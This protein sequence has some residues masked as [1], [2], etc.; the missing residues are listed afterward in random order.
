MSDPSPATAERRSGGHRRRRTIGQRLAAT[1]LALLL[2]GAAGGLT[3]AAA[4]GLGWLPSG[5]ETTA[6]DSACDSPA[7]VTIA[8]DP[9]IAPAVEQLA[10][11]IPCAEVT[12]AA[13]PS[14]DIAAAASRAA[15][16]GLGS[17]LPDLWIPDSS[18]WVE[19][20]RSTSEGAARI[21]GAPRSLAST[22]VVVA[23]ADG[24][25]REL[26]WPSQQPTW[27]DLLTNQSSLRLLTPDPR[28]N[29]AALV[30]LVA[31]SGG[32]PTTET[33][34][35]VSRRLLT[36]GAG[37]ASPAGQI[38]NGSI[39]AAPTTE[40]DVLSVTATPEGEGKVVAAYDPAL[41]PA[42]DFPLV[43]LSPEQESPE[44][45]A[46]VQALSGALTSD[47]A[48][49]AYATLGL[50]TVDGELDESW[51]GAES[52]L[53]DQS[54]TGTL[55]TPAQIQ[56]AQE[57]WSLA[58]RRTRLLLLVDQS[59]SMLEPIDGG[60]T[61]KATVARESLAQFVEVGSPDSEMGLWSFTTDGATPVIDHLVE[62]APLGATGEA[63]QRDALTAGIAALTPAPNG[64]TPLNQ[65]VAEA[66]AAA[67]D[68]YAYG[69][70]NA[71]L[72]V[73]DGKND[74]PGGSISTEDV[75]SGLRLRYDGMRPVR[76]I[77]IG[78]GSGADMAA[79]QSMA[80]ITGGMAA[81]AVTEDQ[82]QT[83]AMNALAT[84]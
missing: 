32:A 21:V 28:T 83:L 77:A 47:D 57:A 15:G 62:V 70:L 34:A 23:I 43:E 51:S 60:T 75:L 2:I 48:Q 50:R 27:H 72:V 63:G 69:K 59:G 26:G 5:T 54:T 9:T 46:A 80:D 73:S 68:S 6:D 79:L 82:V 84:M 3:Y 67:Q 16:T 53:A 74:V 12:I 11:S 66:Y 37:S 7:Q 17:R 22:P 36:A 65:A 64:D 20:A 71:V 56:A 45:S 35:T 41:G 81:L 58:G 14:A 29:T 49:A 24:S 61:P 30:T 10:A 76:I 33:V 55:L 40:A 13:Q 44:R 18:A 4:R 78:Y 42:L 31:E 19:Q 52:V 25:A 1:L 8:A 39:D 38:A